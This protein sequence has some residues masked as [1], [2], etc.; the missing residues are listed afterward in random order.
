[1]ALMLLVSLL[2]RKGSVREWMRRHVPYL[3]RI[4]VFVMLF[5]LIV[6]FGVPASG[7]LGGFMYAEF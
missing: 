3:L 4:C 1:M 6:Y 5:F 2:Q 7:G